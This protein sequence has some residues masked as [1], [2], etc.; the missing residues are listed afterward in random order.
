[1]ANLAQSDFPCESISIKD[2]NP[3]VYGRGRLKVK[4]A[5]YAVEDGK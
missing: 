1:M 2:V 3:L 4:D 5:V